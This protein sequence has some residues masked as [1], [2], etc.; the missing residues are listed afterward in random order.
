MSLSEAVFCCVK[1]DCPV[2]QEGLRVERRGEPYVAL[3]QALC[4]NCVPRESLPLGEC[5]ACF[6]Y[7]ETIRKD[8]SLSC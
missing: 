7:L 3:G 4:H 2:L 6:S 8:S 5:W 1:P